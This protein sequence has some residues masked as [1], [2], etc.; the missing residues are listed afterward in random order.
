ME[1]FS[2]LEKKLMILIESKKSDMA[3]MSELSAELKMMKEE[4]L[5]LAE[6]VES[7]QN[8]SNDDLSK[9]LEENEQLRQQIE[10][11]EDTLLVRHQSIEG[12][13]QERELAKMA[14]DD[15]IK[16]IDI[17]VEHESHEHESQK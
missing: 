11:L 5:K 13:N 12:L 9:L 14:V 4:N 7:A 10:K 16:S 1:H 3:R 6:A 15:L 8:S 2:V 17:L